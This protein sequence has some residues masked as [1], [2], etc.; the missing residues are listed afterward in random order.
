MTSLVSQTQLLS[1][2]AGLVELYVLDCT[3]IGGAIHRFTPIATTSTAP[4]YWQGQMFIPLPI[5]TTGW[6]YNSDGSQKKPQLLVSN[7]TRALLQEVINLGDI[8]GAR[9]IRIRTFSNFLDGAADAD[10]T[11]SY[12][13]DEFIVDQKLTQDASQ[14]VWQMTSVIDRMG[15]KLP[16]RQVTKDGDKRYCA[17]PAVGAFRPSK[18]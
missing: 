16:R 17:F 12:P 4:I 7:V 14:I 2:P 6:E 8:V 5:S 10:P 9:L 13:P 15:V 1:I 3:N 11:Q 18:Y